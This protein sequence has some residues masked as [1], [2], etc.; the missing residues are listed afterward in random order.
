MSRNRDRSPVRT[1]ALVAGVGTLLALGFALALPLP[2]HGPPWRD[3]SAGIRLLVRAEVFF[4]TLN[5]VLLLALA[6]V[7][8]SLHRDLS[9][10]YTLSLV[11]LSLALLLYA[12]TSNPA[13][14]LLLG[15]RPRPNV[16][17]F[18]FVPDLFVGVAIVVL[19][20]QSQT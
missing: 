10:K 6:G 19:F 3:A 9:N 17:A 4:T 12:F 20:Y 2:L 1:T 13:V 8:A 14:H 16:G 5:L 18:V 7:Y 15:L 11:V